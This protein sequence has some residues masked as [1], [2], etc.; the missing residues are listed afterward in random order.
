MGRKGDSLGIMHEFEFWPYKQVLQEH[1]EI[2]PEEWD[3]LNSLQFRDR[4][5]SP[6]IEQKTKSRVD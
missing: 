3:V 1:N 6:N 5:G 2:N 4:N